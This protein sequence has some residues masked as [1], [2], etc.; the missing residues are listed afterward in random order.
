MTLDAR[1]WKAILERAGKGPLSR[2]DVDSLR[3]QVHE[4]AALIGMLKRD[5]VTDDEL[6]ERFPPKSM[7]RETDERRQDGP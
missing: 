7:D 5:D 6:R 1:Q 2:E 3:R 4:Y